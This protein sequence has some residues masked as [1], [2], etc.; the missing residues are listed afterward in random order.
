MHPIYDLNSEAANLSLVPEPLCIREAYA[1]P[2]GS[3]LPIVSHGKILDEEPSLLAC[4]LQQLTDEIDEAILG[5]M[6]LAYG[7]SKEVDVREVD[8]LFS[9]EYQPQPSYPSGFDKQLDYD[10]ETK[11]GRSSLARDE[12]TDMCRH[13]NTTYH[14]KAHHERGIVQ[15]IE[16]GGLQYASDSATM[17]GGLK[18]TKAPQAVKQNK[19]DSK[20][21][22]QQP[23]SAE[24]SSRNK[25][26]QEEDF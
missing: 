15:P 18:S 6:D 20:R 3:R 4:L 21:D 7:R 1:G 16:I 11:P 25:T 23:S 26:R 9:A 8:S 5:Y 17:D 19:N 10:F 22:M 13:E 24:R 14:I 2:N 12:V